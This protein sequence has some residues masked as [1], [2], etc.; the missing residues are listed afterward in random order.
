MHDLFNTMVEYIQDTSK[1]VLVC[2]RNN[3]ELVK[4]LEEVSG[5]NYTLI[6][7]AE[8]ATAFLENMS[9]DSFA[10]CRRSFDSVTDMFD[11]V[12]RVSDNNLIGIIT[13]SRR[14]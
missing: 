5:V 1:S 7:N 9:A 4:R 3:A 13:K 2:G 10:V 14:E 8:Q 11:V 6:D 12:G